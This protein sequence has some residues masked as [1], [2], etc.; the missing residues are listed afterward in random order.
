MNTGCG[1]PDKPT[2]H[3]GRTLGKRVSSKVSRFMK[4]Y[5]RERQNAKG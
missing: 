3:G 2:R 5:L 4:T 1:A